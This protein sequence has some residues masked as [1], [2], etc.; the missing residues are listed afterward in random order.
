MKIRKGLSV[1]IR[2]HPWL[3]FDFSK[4]PRERLSGNR[5]GVTLIEM[6]VVV[7]LI[8]LLAGISYPT[9]SA[10]LDNVRLAS[11]T[12]EVASFL[13]A[14]VTHAERRQ[15][16][17]EVE[18]SLPQ[19]RLVALAADGAERHLNLPDGITLAAVLPPL[20][21]AETGVSAASDAQTGDRR[22]VLFPGATVPAIG[23]ELANRHGGRRI[24]H[25]DPMTGFPNVE[26]VVKK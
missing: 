7:G 3:E 5:R 8:G 10:G 12:E 21:G 13:N 17:V 16:P 20:T 22:F 1:F 2:V 24:V 19:N 9:A 26:S 6:L 4:L 14:A 15:Q 25:L 11:A 23:V 18:I